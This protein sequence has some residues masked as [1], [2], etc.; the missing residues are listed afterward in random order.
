[1]IERVVGKKKLCSS[2]H[3]TERRRRSKC[4]VLSTALGNIQVVL[5]K[6]G[7]IERHVHMLGANSGGSGVTSRI[8]G[9]LLGMHRWDMIRT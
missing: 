4:A 1:M 8:H 6:Q 3:L 9:A 5:N 2:T 7:S